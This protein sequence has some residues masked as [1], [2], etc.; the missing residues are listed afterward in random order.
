[1]TKSTADLAKVEDLKAH[2]KERFSEEEQLKLRQI[3]D[4]LRRPMN[5]K[6]RRALASH[7]RRK[8]W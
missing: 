3:A 1:M 2:M 5:R 8:G 6:Q 4:L 7:T